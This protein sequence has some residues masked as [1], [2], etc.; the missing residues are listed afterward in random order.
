MKTK[1]FANLFGMTVSQ[2]CEFTGYSRDGLNDIVKGDSTKPDSK[3]DMVRKKLL[4]QSTEINRQEQSEVKRKR[5]QRD[6][7][8]LKAFS[9]N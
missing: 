7:A 5:E 2:M 1:E 6:A 3:K 9:R 8:I 4:D